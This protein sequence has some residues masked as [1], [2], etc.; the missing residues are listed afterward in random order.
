MK[1]LRGGGFAL[2]P[3]VFVGVFF[4]YPIATLL[5][6][7]LGIDASR[8]FD[9]VTGTRFLKTIWFTTWQAFAST[10][11]TA[12]V[13]M[14]LT[15]AV[16]NRSFRGRRVARVL[17]TVPF[18]LPTIVVAGAFIAVM[19]SVGLEA[20]ALRSRHTIW[21]ILAAHVFFNIA[22]FVRTVGGFW[23][24]LDRRPEEAARTLGASPLRTFREVTLP[25]LWP[26][27]AAALTV[28]FLFCFTSFAIILRLGGLGRASIET[29]IFRYAISLND[30]STAAAL[31]MVQMVAV[32]A[33][34]G[35][36]G[37]LQGRLKGRQG[38]VVDRGLPST[39]ARQRISLG[40]I[41][42]G[43]AVLLAVPLVVLIER[44]FSHGDGYSFGNYAAL[45]DRVRLLPISALRA[46]GNSLTFAVAAA[47]IALLI[48]GLA[49]LAIVHGS[50]GVSRL[51]DLGMLL[52]LGTSAVTLGFGVL[53]ALDRG[54][55]D[56]RGSW[57]IV[58]IT[59]SLIAIPFVVRGVVPVLRAIDPKL[60]DAASTLG[61]SPLV[62]R[63]EIDLRIGSRALAN[64]VGFAFAIS[65]G[66]FGATSFVGRQPD[67]LTVPLAINRL[68]ATPGD[69]LRG[70]AMA[71]SVILMIVTTLVVLIGDRLHPSSGGM[72]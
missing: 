3:A 70:Q 15:W 8:L 21:A 7:G 20:G 46:L 69:L 39:S 26:S 58:P 66:E 60:R 23:T 53:I 4:A 31:S 65:L 47:G 67:T 62:V 63:R 5:A 33:L 16:A 14:P 42:F 29:E 45:T 43:T 28:V 36:N 57:W 59:Q 27:I 37:W 30:I 18:V 52:P 56:L 38:L 22:V 2:V 71:L 25:R 55:L 41:V 54:V 10:M 19:D 64:G 68:L 32:V 11:L 35:L 12:L 9:V 34:V 40:V 61:A 1:H 50:R 44:S 13:A 17:V 72:L 6:R 48:G 51:L 49:S 24:Q